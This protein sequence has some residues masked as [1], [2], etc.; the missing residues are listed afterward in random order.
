MPAGARQKV[1]H[2]MFGDHQLH[3]VRNARNRVHDLVADRAAQARRGADRV[4]DRLAA[5]G[6]VGLAQVVL[7]HVAGAAREHR[8]DHLH[9]V[10]APAQLDAHELRDR[11]AGEVVLGRAEP[12]AHD[13][14][15][16][17]LEQVAQRRDDPRLV[18]ADRAVLVGVD[19][20]RRELLADPRTVR[21]DDLA[22][23]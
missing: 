14:R 7:R 20:R 17:P 1:G 12:A 21:I 9:E 6:H 4:R 13:H 10:V 22:E 19:P 5:L 18:V 3:L 8:R 2:D 16:G 15:V 11:V 23:Q